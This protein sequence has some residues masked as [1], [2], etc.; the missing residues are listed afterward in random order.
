MQFPFNCLNISATWVCSTTNTKNCRMLGEINQRWEICSPTLTSCQS[1]F[2]LV[3]Q[4]VLQIEIK[5]R[6]ERSRQIKS[7]SFKMSSFISSTML[8][9]R[10]YKHWYTHQRDWARQTA[11]E[12]HVVAAAAARRHLNRRFW[13]L[14]QLHGAEQKTHPYLIKSMHLEAYMCQIK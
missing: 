6:K 3:P 5:E 2:K 4:P 9:S 11:P 8:Y 1:E 10:T 12:Q 7:L 13:M 14:L